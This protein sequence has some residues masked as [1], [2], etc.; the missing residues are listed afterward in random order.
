[1]LHSILTPEQSLTYLQW[2]DANQQRLPQIVG[3]TLSM[4]GGDTSGDSEAVRAILSKNDRDL[5][6]EDVT[7]LLGEL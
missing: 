5:T 4:G 2:V 6:V 7:A 1:M 3:S